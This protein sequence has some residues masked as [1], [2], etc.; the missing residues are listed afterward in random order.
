MGVLPPGCLVAFI[1]DTGHEALV[2]GHPV[3]GLGGC[4]V[5][6]HDLDRLIRAPW[7]EVRRTVMGSPDTPLHAS[8]FLQTATPHDIEAVT[9][10]FREQQFARIGAIVSI[11]TTLAEEIGPAPTIAKTLQNRLLE[12]ARWTS[13]TELKVIFESSDRAN[14]LIEDAFQD[15]GL[16]ENGSPIPIE[17]CFMPKSAGD[18]ALEVADFIVNAVGGQAR[19]NLK[20]QGGFAKDFQAVFHSVDRKLASFMEVQVVSKKV[21]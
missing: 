9:Q 13:F 1:D 10:F 16:L 15:F 21:L 6:G 14:R 3:Y 11:S 8:S 5:M 17:C 4:V 2:R 12:I 18:P 7:R 19:R 20:Q